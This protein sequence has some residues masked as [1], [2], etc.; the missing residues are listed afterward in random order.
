MNCYTAKALRGSI[1]HR[2]HH[3]HPR[4]PELHLHDLRR[5]QHAGEPDRLRDDER[6][7][8]GTDKWDRYARVRKR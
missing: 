8:R 7:H 4:R 3:D 5:L 1:I 6:S 2:S